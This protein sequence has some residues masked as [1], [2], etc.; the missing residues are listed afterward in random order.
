VTP[1]TAK[2]DTFAVETPAKDGD[3]RQNRLARG[4]GALCV[5]PVLW[6]GRCILA[7]ER[8]GMSATLSASTSLCWCQ[9]PVPQELET[10]VLCVQ[11]FLTTIEH[12]C[13][14]LRREIAMG[15]T[16]PSR[17]AEIAEWVKTT[18]NKLTI[19]AYG[20]LRLSD[21]YKKRILT[22]FL[23]LMN[24]HES[25]DRSANRATTTGR[26]RELPVV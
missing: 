13:S 7:L 18:A 26:G 21:E 8:V 10:E 20:R 5:R 22:A 11:H 2:G 6:Y 17:Q 15:K 4:I 9:L 1:T 19:V 16:T 3:S 14:E 12:D 25:L 23:T 24:L